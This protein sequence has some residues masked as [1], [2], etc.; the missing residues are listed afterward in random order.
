MFHFLR[1]VTKYFIKVKIFFALHWNTYYSKTRIISFLFSKTSFR[2]TILSDWVQTDSIAISWSTSTEKSTGSAP[3]RA[4]RNRD[5]YF[6]AYVTPVSRCTIFFT[7]TLVNWFLKR[8]RKRV[9]N[10][11]R[12]NIRFIRRKTLN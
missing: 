4:F 8:K 11:I 10:Y 2:W 9:C 1:A 12:R 5:E 3:G 7:V 6:A